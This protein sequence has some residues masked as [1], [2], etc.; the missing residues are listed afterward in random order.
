MLTVP[1]ALAEEVAE[2][3][4]L[5]DGDGILEP[6]EDPD[7][8][9]VRSTQNPVSMLIS[10][11]FQSNWNFNTGPRNKT[12]HILNIQPV[13]PI[14]LNDDWNLITRTIFPILSQPSFAPGMDRENG[15]GDIQFSAFFAPA[16]SGKIIWGVG[17]SIRFPTA[18]DD[19]LGSE[20]WS[21]GPSAVALTMKGPW[22][23]GGL[24]QN[25][26]SFAGDDD[27]SHVNQFLLQPFINYNLPDSWYINSSPVITAD[28]AADDSDDRW[29]VPIGGGVG[30]IFTIGKLPVNCSLATYYN[31]ETPDNGGPDWQVRF[32]IQFLFPK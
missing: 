17:P 25:I 21:A 28:W 11:P 29:T 9:L 31:V 20:K 27:R 18:T 7:A 24:V 32:Q 26:W 8:E 1:V 12:Q 19:V 22:V 13:Y 5:F 6:G 3:E 30:K 14:S 23:F 16:E 4:V 10:V 2:G 15:L